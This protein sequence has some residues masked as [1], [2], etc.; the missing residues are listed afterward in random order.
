MRAVQPTVLG[1]HDMRRGYRNHLVTQLVRPLGEADLLGT[2]DR[3]IPRLAGRLE[4]QHVRHRKY[5]FHLF[6]SCGLSLYVV[7][8]FRQE[9]SIAQS[10]AKKS[11]PDFVDR[12][13]DAPQIPAD[14]KS[15]RSELQSLMRIS[16]AV[17][18]LKKKNE[19]P[20]TELDYNQS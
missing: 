19:N 12:I 8:V 2:G 1:R 13:G 4:T 3:S 16:Y 6:Y 9:L 10:R 14:R 11:D 17:F 18:C 5:Q 7:R 20:N 15:T